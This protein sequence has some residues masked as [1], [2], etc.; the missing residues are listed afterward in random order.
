MLKMLTRFHQ[1]CL[2]REQEIDQV[3]GLERKDGAR[4]DR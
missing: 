3:S 1:S 2:E 4:G